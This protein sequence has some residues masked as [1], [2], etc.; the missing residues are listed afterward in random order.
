MQ[1]YNTV[2][3]WT[4]MRKTAQKMAAVDMLPRMWITMPVIHKGANCASRHMIMSSW[5][6]TTCHITWFISE[7]VMSGKQYYHAS[8]SRQTAYICY[9]LLVNRQTGKWYNTYIS[10]IRVLTCS[11]AFLMAIQAIKNHSEQISVV[12]QCSLSVSLNVRIFL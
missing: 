5:P 7:L 2:L 3:K 12:Q 9:T 8:G 1:W 11:L 6:A 10:G 4:K